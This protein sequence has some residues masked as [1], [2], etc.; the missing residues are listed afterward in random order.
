MDR[1]P[2]QEIGGLRRE[3]GVVDAD[4]VVPLPGARLIV[5]EGVGARR[6]VGRAGLVALLRQAVEPL[7]LPDDPGID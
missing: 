1:H 5:P 4:A 3:Q 7:R 6:A 2:L